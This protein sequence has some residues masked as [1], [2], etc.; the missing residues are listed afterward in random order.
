MMEVAS[1]FLHKSGSLLIMKNTNVR[2]QNQRDSVLY[3]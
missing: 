2:Y 1:V 3:C